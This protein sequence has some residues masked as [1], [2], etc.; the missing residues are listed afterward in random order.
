MCQNRQFSFS[1]YLCS[2]FGNFLGRTGGV[3]YLAL[4]FNLIAICTFLTLKPSDFHAT[5]QA[6]VLLANETDEEGLFNATVS[7]EI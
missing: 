1:L 5:P 3:P 6:Q 2:A 4:P 7:D